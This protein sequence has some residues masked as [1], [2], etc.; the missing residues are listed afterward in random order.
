MRR[1]FAILAVLCGLAT[2][3]A[4]GTIRVAIGETKTEDVGFAKGLRCDDTSIANIA[5]TTDAARDVNVLSVTGVAVG[6]TQC[7]VGSELGRPTFLYAIE[8]VAAA[9]APKRK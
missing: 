3:G 2:A 5:L 7:R 1:S 9:P 8:V 4:P 6:K